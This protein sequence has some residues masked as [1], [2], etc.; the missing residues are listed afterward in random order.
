MRGRDFT[1]PTSEREHWGGAAR[2]QDFLR[3]SLLPMIETTYRSNPARRVV[4]GQSLDRQRAERVD[5]S[6]CDH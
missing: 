1:T 4:F 3:G 5:D 6:S 2:F